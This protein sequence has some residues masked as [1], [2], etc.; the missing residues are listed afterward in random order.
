MSLPL[1]NPLICH[2]WL[3]KLS[4]QKSF[5]LGRDRWQRRY[6]VLTSDDKFLYA[7]SPQE[8]RNPLGT[9]PTG[10]ITI[11]HLSQVNPSHAASPSNSNPS[12]NL[13]SPDSGS[14]P[15]SPNGQD[16]SP[17]LT[18]PN[19]PG[20]DFHMIV[21]E[22]RKFE[23]RAESVSDAKL[24]FNAIK[25]SKKEVPLLPPP[26]SIADSAKFHKPISEYQLKFL[27][28]KYS[29]SEK[30]NS[31]LADW[32]LVSDQLNGGGNLN[33]KLYFILGEEGFEG[34]ASPELAQ[35]ARKS[36]QDRTLSQQL[37]PGSSK[38]KQRSTK[39]PIKSRRSLSMCLNPA[40]SQL[41]VTINEGSH[42]NSE[43]NEMKTPSKG[44]HSNGSN[45]TEN[46]ASPRSAKAPVRLQLNIPNSAKNS[47]IK[48]TNT[49]TP[50]SISISNSRNLT[51]PTSTETSATNSTLSTPRSSNS[52]VS[53]LSQSLE[54][55]HIFQF[56]PPQ[57]APSSPNCVVFIPFLD[58]IGIEGSKTI[59]PNVNSE[60]SA[61]NSGKSE[62]CQKSEWISEQLSDCFDIETY[63]AL[64]RFN[65]NRNNNQDSKENKKILAQWIQQ[66]NL[67]RRNYYR[68]WKFQL[69]LNKTRAANAHS[70]DSFY[71]S[72]PHSAHPM[73]HSEQLSD[74]NSTNNDSSKQNNEFNS[75]YLAMLE[76]QQTTNTNNS[77]NS[78]DNPINNNNSA[79][80][81]QL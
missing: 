43:N 14:V 54:N 74:E 9:I 29:D 39:S 16:A 49:S 37:Q 15:P 60:N 63:T 46:V 70:A 64:W 47:A 5:L 36:A 48:I 66:L 52:T 41:Y 24:W 10:R 8:L 51:S 19:L 50:L 56:L 57:P 78:A 61:W 12:K 55:C 68:Q 59:R 62:N 71:H 21:D 27:E 32:L 81:Q 53:Y 40:P 58:I 77:T 69:A 17:R 11:L 26:V 22:N 13:N 44:N 76:Q 20:C 38:D 31:L 75:V 2:G 1:V 4:P 34:Y 42:N 28:K 18:V 6:F 67:A 7:K 33:E 80:V 45:S 79:A 35:D 65:F 72:E 3:W 73:T 23:F 30:V 25:K